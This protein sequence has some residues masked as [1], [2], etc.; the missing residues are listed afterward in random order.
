MAIKALKHALLTGFEPFG[1]P[2]PDDNRSWE[3]IKQL[4]NE[5]IETDSTTILCHCY[6]IPVSYGPVS[7]LAHKSGY[8]NPGNGGSADVSADGHVPV[9]ADLPETLETEID[10][11][12]LRDHLIERG[13][14]KTEVSL[15]PGRYLCDFTYYTSLAEARSTYEGRG[16]APP[17]TLFVHVPPKTEDPYSD[18]RTSRAALEGNGKRNRFC[19]EVAQV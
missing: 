17:K 19:M 10:V 12:G 18:L 1:N 11:D 13:W 8:T 15:D 7:E 9:A 5:C 16:L 2:V 14:D 3:T 6:E 4:S